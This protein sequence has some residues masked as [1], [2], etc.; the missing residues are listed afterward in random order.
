M[1]SRKSRKI[2]AAFSSLLAFFIML[3]VLL[4][5]MLG[6]GQTQ[7]WL[8]IFQVTIAYVPIIV[9][10]IGIA[11]V[12]GLITFVVLTY[13][14]R[15]EITPIAEKMRLLANGNFENMFLNQANDYSNENQELAAIHQDISTT[16]EKMKDMSSQLQILNT[17]PQSIN[18]QTK[19][20]ILEN[21]RHRL[22]REL[23]D[24]VSQEL[25]AAMMMMSAVTEQTK[26]VDIPEA[27]Q[28]QLQMI[29]SIINTSQSEMRALL[30]HLRPVTLEE[31]SLK[32]GIEQLL[33]ELQTKITLSLTW[34]IEDLNIPRHI[35]DQLFRV[36]QELLSNTLRHS[37]AN[38][39]EVYLHLIDKNILLRV[40]DDGVGF[41]PEQKERTGSYGL[42]NVRERMAAIGG[43]VKVISFKGQ[44]T[45]IEIKIPLME[46]VS[47]K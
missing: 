4:F 12:C 8:Q 39:L 11:L 15:K 28:K 7:R 20:E 13:F 41:N 40:V 19:E 6:I 5:Y 36:V 22:A 10:L 33:Q 30:L 42:R 26:E 43:T 45:S 2:L 47:G 14:Q 16:K 38:E 1:T 21:E 46:E 23:H 34:E 37:K 24:S 29:S 18:G 25:F 32:K 17:R 9:Y 31:K 27:Q 3:L 44:G 35:E